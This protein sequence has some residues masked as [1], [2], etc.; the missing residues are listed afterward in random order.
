MQDLTK[1]PAICSGGS[2]SLQ[3]APLSLTELV[4]R[5]LQDK[6]KDIDSSNVQAPKSAG[7]Y[8]LTS[9]TMSGPRLP[10]ATGF[11]R[12]PQYLPFMRSPMTLVNSIFSSPLSE[13]KRLSRLSNATHCFIDPISQTQISLSVISAKGEASKLMECTFDFKC[14]YSGSA[15]LSFAV[16]DGHNGS[17][18][19]EYLQLDD[20]LLLALHTSV[21]PITAAAAAAAAFKIVNDNVPPYVPDTAGASVAVCSI[22]TSPTSPTVWLVCAN[23]GDVEVGIAHRGAGIEIVSTCHIVSKNETERSRLTQAKVT[24]F[25]ERVLGISKYT[26]S[27]GDRAAAAIDLTGEARGVICTP[28]TSRTQLKPDGSSVIIFGNSEFWSTVLQSQQEKIE[29]SKIIF[30]AIDSGCDSGDIVKLLKQRTNDLT[31][32]NLGFGIV[33]FSRK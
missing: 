25:G 28:S 32:E 20:G 27:I 15:A 33:M 9:A 24:V 11:S 17:D 30:D 16:Y 8:D 21:N 7:T 18:V 5:E 6:T 12:K 19:A 2:R 3:V 4:T 1:P 29:V 14:C 31:S 10:S 23:V 26:R 22:F 13:N